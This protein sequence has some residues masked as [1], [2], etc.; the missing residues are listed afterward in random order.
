VQQSGALR[1]YQRAEFQF[2]TLLGLS[3]SFDWLS[4]L[5]SKTGILSVSEIEGPFSET[6]TGVSEAL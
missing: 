3:K 5:F 6:E 4:V 1:E 2:L